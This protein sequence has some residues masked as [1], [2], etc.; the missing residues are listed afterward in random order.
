VVLAVTVSSVNPRVGRSGNLVFALFAFVVYFNLLNL[1]QSWISTGR[2]SFAGYLVTLHGGTLA[3]ALLWLG[4]Q[5]NNWALPTLLR[6][7]RPEAA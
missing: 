5:H 6:R 1:G 3:A 4:K 2:S 7:R